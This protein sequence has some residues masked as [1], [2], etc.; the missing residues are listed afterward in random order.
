MKTNKNQEAALP[1]ASG[2]PAPLAG[3]LNPIDDPYAAAQQMAV[4]MVSSGQL[5]LPSDPV[6][7][8]EQTYEFVQ[9]LTRQYLKLREF[10]DRSH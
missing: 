3:V 1:E 4:A 7:A 6:K 5:K 2:W 8:A 9:A 10:Y